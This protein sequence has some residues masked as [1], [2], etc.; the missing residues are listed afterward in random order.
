LPD[1]D[2]VYCVPL[3]Q[4]KNISPLALVHALGNT[5]TNV[6]LGRVAV[7][8]TH[9]IKVPSGFRVAFRPCFNLARFWHHHACFAPCS[10]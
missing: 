4:L 6:S 9:T 5:L 1:R 7:S 8:F 2:V 3:L 10:A